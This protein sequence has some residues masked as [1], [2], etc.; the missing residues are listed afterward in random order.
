MQYG[1]NNSQLYRR[2]LTEEI[3]WHLSVANQDTEHIV[4]WEKNQ[5]T[6]YTK[7]Q[8]CVSFNCFKWSVEKQTYWKFV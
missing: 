6:L 4:L 8:L 2:Y 5:E 1:C 3:D 7:K